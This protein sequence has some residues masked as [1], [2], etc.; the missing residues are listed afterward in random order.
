MI[1]ADRFDGAFSDLFELQDR[2][3]MRV[4]TAIAPQVRDR[5]LGRGMRKHPSS[6]TAYDLTLQA[7]EQIY[8]MSR[9]SFGEARRLLQEAI[10]HD[11]RY[12]LAYSYLAY[13][14]ILT[15]GQGWSEDVELDGNRTI[16]AAEAAL[17]YDHN[18]AMALAFYGHMQSFV[19]KDFERATAFLD[20]AI[21]VGPSCAWAWTM[22]SF[23]C[24]YR[25]DVANALP[26]AEQGVRLSPV[27]PDA[28]WH[29]GAL[30]QAHYINGS[31][32]EAI[33]WGRMSDSKSPDN[34]SNL[35]VLIASSIAAGDQEG[36]ARYARR[37]RRVAPE[38]SLEVLRKRTPLTGKIRD[39]FIQRL[40]S[41]GLPD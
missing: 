14:Q 3:A 28:F 8:R 23:T 30:S 6:M 35:R 40:R 15:I 41:A 5:E 2:I 37:F 19:L 25:G 20:R 4:V 32:E 17:Q 13:L 38:F 34:G 1:W 26:R 11:R 7:L 22:S 31:Y 12:A 24:Q 18:D 16:A 21:V 29:E 27:G 9:E 36:A 39:T 10:T 33:S